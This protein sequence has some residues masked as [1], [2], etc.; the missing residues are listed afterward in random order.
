[1]LHISNHSVGFTHQLFIELLLRLVF[2]PH[3]SM[4]EIRKILELDDISD[5]LATYVI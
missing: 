5:L 4:V 3:E 2:S 1:M